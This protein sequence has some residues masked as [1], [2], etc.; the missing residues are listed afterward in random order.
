MN[1]RWAGNPPPH[2]VAYYGGFIHG[3]SYNNI[4]EYADQG[5]LEDFMK[6]T[7][8]PK[9]IEGNLLFWDRL[10][11]VIHGIMTIHGKIGDHSSASQFLNGYVLCPVRYVLLLILLL[12]DGIK[13]LN[14]PTFS[15]LVKTELHHMTVISRSRTLDSL[16]SNPAS[17]S[18]MIPQTLT[19]LALAHMVRG[20]FKITFSN[21]T[22]G[23]SGAPETYRSHGDAESTPLQVTQSVDIW[24]IGC[25][26]S[27]ASVWAHYGWKRMIEYRRQRSVEI[28][29][30]GGGEGEHLFHYDGTLLNVVKNIHEEILRLPH[31]IHHITRSVLDRLVNDMLQHGQRPPAAWLFEKSKRLVKE[32]ANRFDVP[33]VK[34]G[35]NSNGELVDCN[36]ARISARRELPPREPPPSDDDLAPSSLSSRS[37][38]SPHRHHHKSTSQNSNLRSVDPT[39]ISQSSG[40]DSHVVPNPPPSTSTTANGDE[41]SQRQPVQQCQN[42]PGRPTLSIDEGHGWKKKKKKGE[43]AVLPGSENL[44]YLSQRDHVSHVKSRLKLANRWS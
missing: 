9:D 20:T 13:M 44:T 3:N 8:P 41:S 19:P 16:I 11:D 6:T 17:P 43:Y 22:D 24:S 40:Q 34:L 1:L 36:P 21:V 10:S 25:V 2:I 12:P 30:N 32:E 14:Q 29:N 7:D 27:E 35:R 38:S 15:S 4:F 42:E 31:T 37:Q 23:Y 26:F 39:N 5:T 28:K 18:Q 33:S